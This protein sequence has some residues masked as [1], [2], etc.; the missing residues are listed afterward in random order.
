MESTERRL[1]TLINKTERT[2]QETSELYRLQVQSLEG[3]LAVLADNPAPWAVHLRTQIIPALL[4][5]I[6]SR[7]IPPPSQAAAP[8]APV[9]HP[10]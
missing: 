5:D 3:Q 6:Q 9:P 10:Q 2:A 7:P 4:A 8:F 1:F